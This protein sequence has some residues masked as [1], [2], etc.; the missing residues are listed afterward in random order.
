[1]SITLDTT[2]PKTKTT[3]TKNSI[4]FYEIKNMNPN[5]KK[6]E[7]PFHTDITTYFMSLHLCFI[8]GSSHFN[9]FQDLGL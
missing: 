4:Q 1:M 3:S 7:V 2:V 9:F 6:A 5:G 8:T